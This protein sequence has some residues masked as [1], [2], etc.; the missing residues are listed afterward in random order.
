MSS[1]LRSPYFFLIKYCQTLNRS[2][3]K[4]KTSLPK[5][6]CQNKFFLCVLH[7]DQFHR[8]APGENWFA[9]GKGLHRLA[10]EI[11]CSSLTI[12]QYENRLVLIQRSNLDG[13]MSLHEAGRVLGPFF[14]STSP[15]KY[16]VNLPRNFRLGKN[17]FWKSHA[18]L[19]NSWI[20]GIF[21]SKTSQ[22]KLP[23]VSRVCHVRHHG[24]F[25]KNARWAS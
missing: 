19:A 9:C 14:L 21:S 25:W 20:I 12:N 6:K 2:W 7:V 17:A 8:F 16:P 1:L 5:L 3:K 11:G 15:C 10:I 24:C 4:Q 13:R 23:K 22:K 18:F